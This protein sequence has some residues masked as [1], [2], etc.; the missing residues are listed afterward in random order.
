MSRRRVRAVW[1]V[2]GTIVAVVGMFCL[3]TL[4]VASCHKTTFTAEIESWFK[5]GKEACRAIS[6][7]LIK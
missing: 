7:T 5:T 3:A 6:N 4:I 1:I 2:L